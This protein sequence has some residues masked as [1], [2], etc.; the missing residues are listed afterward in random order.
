[1][2]GKNCTPRHRSVILIG[3]MG[4]GKSTTG[5]YI[6]GSN[7]FT[8]G[9][10]VNRITEMI[11][12]ETRNGITI[13]D[14]PG[15]GDDKGEKIVQE[16]FLKKRPDLISMCSLN[17]IVLL[18]KFDNKDCLAFLNAA[19]D[20]HKYF[21]APAI[22]SL[23]IMCIQSGNMRYSDWDF[24][25]ILYANEGYQYLKQKNENRNIHYLLWDNFTPYFNQIHTFYSKLD[26]ARYYTSDDMLYLFDH[27]SEI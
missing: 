10:S 17:A 8:S 13:A 4:H 12:I 26:Q 22:R 7:A 18:V 1:M 9:S 15:F 25:E 23:V 3:P 20:F 2:G 11:Q 27:I 19:K 16:T 24:E 5:N 21:G 6:L 14:C